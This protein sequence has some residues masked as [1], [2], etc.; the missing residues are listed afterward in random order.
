MPYSITCST[1]TLTLA[2]TPILFILVGVL[3]EFAV[4]PAVYILLSPQE[5][6]VHYSS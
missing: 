1:E 4:V 5:A 3:C 2:I 6:K